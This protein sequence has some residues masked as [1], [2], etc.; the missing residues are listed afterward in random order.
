MIVIESGLWLNW[1]DCGVLLV[2][3][4]DLVPGLTVGSLEKPSDP[5]Q[6]ISKDRGRDR[7]VAPAVAL[8]A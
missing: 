3:D 7:P 4:Q 8:A 2:D 1:R 6:L 5:A